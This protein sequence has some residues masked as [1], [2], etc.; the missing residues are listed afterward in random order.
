[1]WPG[2]DARL[3]KDH[4]FAASSSDLMESMLR[5]LILVTGAVCFLYGLI[6]PVFEPN[7]IVP[8]A[9][10]ISPMILITCAIPLWLVR[11]NLLAAQV[12]WMA[13]MIVDIIFALYVIQKPEI[14]FLFAIIP[15]VAVITSGWLAG[16][17]AEGLVIAAAWW[18]SSGSRLIPVQISPGYALAI[19]AWGLLAGLFGWA[20]VSPLFSVAQWS[21]FYY[22][23]ASA[24]LEEARNTQMELKQAQEDLVHANK[25]LA[26]LSDRLK[27]LHQLAEEARRAKESFVANVSHELRTPLNMIIGFSEMITRSP[28]VY[29]TELPHALLADITTIHRNS[30][31]LLK[32][33]NDVL[34]L[35]QVDAGRM[36]LTKEWASLHEIIDSAVMAVRALFESKGLYLET[37]IAADLPPVY[38]D[39]TRIR[40]VALN[41]LSNASRF[42]QR[43]GVR[44]QARLHQDKIIVSV[45]DT[46][47]GIASDDQNK[48]FEPFQQLDGSIRRQ[49]GGSGLGLSISK[50]FV[51]MHGGEMWLESQLGIGT[52]FNFSLLS[53]EPGGAGLQGNKENPLMR[54]FNPYATYQ[55][56]Y[57]PFKA[58]L[59][60]A[61]PRFL[62]LEKGNTLLRRLE[63]FMDNTEITPVKGLPEA[64]DE[65]RRSPARALIVN[66]PTLEDLAIS[67]NALKELPY[68]TPAISCWV[69]GEEDAAKQLG[70]MRYLVKPVTGEALLLALKDA[71]DDVES[72]LLVDDELELLRLFSR[73][74]TTADPKYRVLRA[75]NGQRALSLL[76]QRKPDVMVLDL[77]MPG[78]DGFQ[79]LRQKSQDPEIRD[80]P[81]IIISSRDP[82]GEPIESDMLT[83]I[84]SG[85]FSI[86]HLLSCIQSI[87][88]I[89]SPSSQP[90]DPGQ[91]EKT[92][93]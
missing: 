61:A 24:K 7:L 56:R 71:G 20:G 41:L 39:S 79:V 8:L 31:H 52:T 45:T 48:L 27:V 78:L 58:P 84:R 18:L 59:Q 53:S 4:H 19:T 23:Q 85:G 67:A 50:R 21:L 11:R 38:C 10:L 60:K 34:D 37:E 5:N 42:T 16:A 72:V 17:L 32:L 88:E 73:V 44:I 86:H 40:Q 1:M 46:G 81:V 28:R 36:A 6:V 55:E 35:S 64:I 69:P 43:G 83:V 62:L 68:G 91:P 49:Y 30:Q 74:F 2:L 51:E 13:G 82:T 54:W 77:I 92:A 76:K 80:I 12:A 15:F 47:P 57:R 93:V 25:E 22:S 89:L 65:L 75:T 9:Y 66:T 87:S 90:A 33:V 3:V 29:G 63:R 70:V 26:R 14:A